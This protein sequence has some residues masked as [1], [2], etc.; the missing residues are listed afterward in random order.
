MNAQLPVRER[1][2]SEGATADLQPAGPATA[3]LHRLAAY[4][5]AEAAELPAGGWLRRRLESDVADGGWGDVVLPELAALMRE[6]EPVAGRWARVRADPAPLLDAEESA[7]RR[8]G[9]LMRAE[10]AELEEAAP[11]LAR[12]LDA[13]G[14][15]LEIACER[16]EH[17][18]RSA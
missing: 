7:V 12:R 3:A 4:M 9:A 16:P 13:W 2:S 11:A 8:L 14:I 10:A 15:R 6:A 18:W 5:H 1:P 17:S